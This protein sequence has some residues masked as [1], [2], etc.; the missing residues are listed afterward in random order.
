MDER[1]TIVP[2]ELADGSVVRISATPLGGDEDVADLPGALSFG[3][4]SRTVEGMAR[5][6]RACL[7]RVN[8]DKASIEFGIEVAVES[9]H[10]TALI[11]KGSA[12]G[13]LKVVLS[14]DLGKA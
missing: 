7:D 13:N 3:E 12:K 2:V 6:L 4:V 14:W 1:E 9:G 11:A 8:P 5:E 10:L